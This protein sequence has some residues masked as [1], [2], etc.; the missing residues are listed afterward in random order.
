MVLTVSFGLSPVIGLFVTVASVMRKHPANLT[1]ASRRQDHTTS[2]S[3]H[4]CVRLA[5]DKH[6]SHPAPNVRDDRETPLVRAQD[7]R[8]LPVIWGGDQSRWPATDWHD[9]QISREAKSCVK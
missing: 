5:P 9:G 7:L 2:P 1:P 3:A 4:P 6:P 8:I